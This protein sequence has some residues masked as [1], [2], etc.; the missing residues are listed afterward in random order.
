MNMILY[1][2]LVFPCSVVKP[3]SLF[4]FACNWSRIPFVSERVNVI[5]DGRAS[6]R[7]E[8]L[9]KD[10]S[11]RAGELESSRLSFQQFY[12]FLPKTV[13][14]LWSHNEWTSP[15][16]GFWYSLPCEQVLHKGGYCGRHVR[17]WESPVWARPLPPKIR[18]CQIAQTKRKWSSDELRNGSNNKEMI[19][20]KIK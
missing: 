18:S 20:L 15:A 12:T 19:I 10:L 13:G 7:E 17:A 8:K 11:W 6:F 14:P 16:G 4:K 1:S 9:A 5:R 2:I 3:I